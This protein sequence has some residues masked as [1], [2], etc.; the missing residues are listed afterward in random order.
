VL[1]GCVVGFVAEDDVVV[2]VVVVADLVILESK[3]PPELDRF[4]ESKSNPLRLDEDRVV[5]MPGGG[6][7]GVGALSCLLRFFPNFFLPLLLPG[8][9]LRP[10]ARELI[11]MLSNTAARARF[12][13]SDSLSRS[14]FFQSKLSTSST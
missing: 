5:I 4:V 2:V 12:L 6:V 8:S 11:L 9:K 3:P 7:I 13:G 14:R 10:E 1:E